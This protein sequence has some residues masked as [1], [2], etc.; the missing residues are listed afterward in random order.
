MKVKGKSYLVAEQT[1]PFNNWR[2]VSVQPYKEA[3]V[4]ISAIFNK[5][6]SFQIISFFVFMLLLVGLLRTFTNPLVRLGKVTAAVQ[7]GNLDIRSGIR[8]RDEIG[9]LG[10]LFDQMLDRVRNMIAEV[11]ET[12]ARKRKAELRMLQAQI[13]PHFLFNV[14]NSIRMKVMRGGD[15]DSAKMIG[16]LSKLLRMTISSDKDEIHFH[17]EI[18]LI[19]HYVELM[20]LRQKEEVRLQLDISSE[21]F[22]FKVPRL[23]LQP[24]VENALIH[25]L[26]QSRGTLT[27]RAAMK[28]RGLELTVEDD[29]NG[30]DAGQLEKLRRSIRFHANQAI[31]LDEQRKGFSGIG[32]QN[33]VER[34]K[35]VYGEEFRME[36]YSEAGQRTLVLMCIPFKEGNRHV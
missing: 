13:N 3:I 28:E 31:Y 21:A 23:F 18:E 8:G 10:F 4:N 12:Q 24:V 33:V 14:L 35:I 30:M 27:I 15:K 5:V 6:F 34:M 7:R 25:G 22:L 26:S 36:V 9:R 29:G 11:S 2:L 32:L 1:I 20:N 16:S 19:T 17:E